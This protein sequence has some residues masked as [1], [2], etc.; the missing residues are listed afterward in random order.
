MATTKKTNLYE[1][2]VR[3]LSREEARKTRGG[4]G[5]PAHRNPGIIIA[6]Q[7]SSL[8]SFMRSPR[9]KDSASFDRE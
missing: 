6:L 5:F 7:P 8:P 2:A 4:S 3:R 9:P 1:R